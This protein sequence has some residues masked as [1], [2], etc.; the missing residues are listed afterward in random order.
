PWSV[1]LA[2]CVLGEAVRLGPALPVASPARVRG[3]R[4]P[5]D[6]GPGDAYV[7]ALARGLTTKGVALSRAL[8]RP[9]AHDGSGVAQGHGTGGV[10]HGMAG[11]RAE[12]ASVRLRLCAPRLAPAGRRTQPEGGRGQ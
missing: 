7:G 5:V 1:V 2:P 9:T 12:T 3:H 11:R 10:A 4:L 8:T 6:I